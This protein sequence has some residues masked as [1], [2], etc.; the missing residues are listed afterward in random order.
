MKNFR[1]KQILVP[2]GME[3]LPK[4]QTRL[5]YP[6]KVVPVTNQ[7]SPMTDLQILHPLQVG[8]ATNDDSLVLFGHFGKLRFL[9]MGDLPQNGEKLIMKQYPNLQADVL[10]LGHHGSKTSSNLAFLKQVQPHYGIISAGRRNRY[11]HPNL[12]TMQRL[13]Q[14]KIV[15]LSTQNYGMIRY[16]YYSFYDQLTTK[17]NGDEKFW[18]SQP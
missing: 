5:A 8:S 7:S 18:I 12:E 3:T 4:F 13:Q 14:S 17:L 1:V 2:A 15:P 10:K 16:R 6:V 11:H 9:F